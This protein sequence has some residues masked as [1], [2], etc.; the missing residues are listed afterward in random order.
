MS[1]L[2]E[3][4]PSYIAPEHLLGP[5]PAPGER[6]VRM[7]AISTLN[8]GA[9]LGGNTNAMGNDTDRDLFLG[10]RQWADAILVGANT[11]RLEEYGRVS[12]GNAAQLRARQALGQTRAPVMA[13]LSR[14]LEFPDLRAFRRDD[15]DDPDGA[16]AVPLVLTPQASLDDS[17]LAHHRD[18]LTEA[19]ALLVSTG[20]GR[21]QDVIDALTARGLN[22]ISCEGGPG[23]LSLFLEADLIDVAHLTVE[24][25]FSAPVEHPLLAVRDDQEE[26][27][28]AF[29]LEQV[30]PTDDGFVFLRYRRNRTD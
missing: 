20:E 24:P 17:A 19:G 25:M 10:A 22:R 16:D 15:S 12:Y 4:F 14:S 5:G 1:P 13:V 18:E 27:S 30:S 8:G 29:R 28:R 2:N 6:E 21:P 26:F 9:S 3:P 11:V 7:V 23:I